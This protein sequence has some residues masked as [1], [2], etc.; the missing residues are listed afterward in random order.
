MVHAAQAG[1][2]CTCRAARRRANECRTEFG[3]TSRSSRRVT[4]TAKPFCTAEHC[5]K[6]RG[7]G[8]GRI[9]R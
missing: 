1:K 8:A 3:D 7:A 5:H 6:R 4:T 2:R 9:V